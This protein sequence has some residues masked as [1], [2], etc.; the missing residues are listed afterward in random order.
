[1]LGVI[2]IRW[3]GPSFDPS[4]SQVG[5]ETLEFAHEGIQAS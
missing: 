5:V 1:M 3:Q 4:Q 2:P